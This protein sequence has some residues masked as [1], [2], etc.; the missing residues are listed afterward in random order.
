MAKLI[1]TVLCESIEFNE[2]SQSLNLIGLIHGI[3][4]KQKDKSDITS[5]ES[6]VAESE[7]WSFELLTTWVRDDEAVEEEPN[8][9]FKFLDPD[10]KR[11][12]DDLDVQISLKQEIIVARITKITNKLNLSRAGTHHIII[13]QRKDGHQRFKTMADV[14]LNIDFCV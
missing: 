4:L 11:L 3:T 10:G 14:P 13:M 6:E 7:E 12:L 2:E 9:R 1:N 8:I 5:A